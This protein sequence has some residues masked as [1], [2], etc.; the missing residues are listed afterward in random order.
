MIFQIHNI[1]YLFIN[2]QINPI[3]ITFRV[4]EVKEIEMNM[5]ESDLKN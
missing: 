2:E 5:I 4:R 3:T 1:L